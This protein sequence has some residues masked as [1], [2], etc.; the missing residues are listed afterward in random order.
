M[1]PDMQNATSE[2][3]VMIA[4]S[5]PVPVVTYHKKIREVQRVKKAKHKY[6]F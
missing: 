2:T 1:W 6:S 5:P 4:Y 3:E